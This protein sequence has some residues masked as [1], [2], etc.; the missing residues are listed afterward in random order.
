MH[1]MRRHIA[2]TFSLLLLSVAL[3]GATGCEMCQKYLPAAEIDNPEEGSPE[4]V[5]R[6]LIIAA[7]EKDTSKGWPKFRAYL[8]SSQLESPASESTWRKMNFEAFHRSVHLLLEDPS[9]PIFK[10]DYTETL[11]DRRIKLFV[12]NKGSE[13]PKPFL[14]VKDPQANDEWRLK[15]SLN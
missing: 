5:V 10:R 14:L 4:Y 1:A 15:G 13:M 2:L 8:H 11:D 3:L 7:M 9:K 12:V 6:Q